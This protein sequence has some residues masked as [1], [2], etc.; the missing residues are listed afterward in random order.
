MLLH[1]ITVISFGRVCKYVWV[2]DWGI[3]TR[4]GLGD[5]GDLRMGFAK[6]K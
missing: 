5:W 1:V 3:R 4:S 6:K 2:C